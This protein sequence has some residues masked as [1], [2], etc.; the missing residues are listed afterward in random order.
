MRHYTE[1]RP[2]C[3]P[4]LMEELRERVLRETNIELDVRPPPSG[5]RS[6]FRCGPSSF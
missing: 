1:A 3:D 5:I 4:D 6:H 2:S